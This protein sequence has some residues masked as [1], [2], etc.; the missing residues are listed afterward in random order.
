MYIKKLFL[1]LNLIVKYVKFELMFK[2]Y[3]YKGN[4]A[5]HIRKALIKR[6]NWT[7]VILYP[8]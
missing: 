4:Y 8:K 6:E 7:E 3:V 2:F 1:F 5:N